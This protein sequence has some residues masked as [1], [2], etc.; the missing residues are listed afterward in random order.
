MPYTERNDTYLG[1]SGNVEL[2][3]LAH[4][5]PNSAEIRGHIQGNNEAV[6]GHLHHGL[7]QSRWCVSDTLGGLVRRRRE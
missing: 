7:K 3:Q 2:V 5:V 4:V 6:K 1:Q